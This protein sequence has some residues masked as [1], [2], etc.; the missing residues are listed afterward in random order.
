VGKKEAFAVRGKRWKVIAKR[1]V[2]ELGRGKDES[3]VERGRL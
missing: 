2:R 1:R 3:R